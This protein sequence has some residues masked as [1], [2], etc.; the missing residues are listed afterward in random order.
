MNLSEYFHMG[1]YALYVWLSY[2]L[3]LAVIVVH[4]VHPIR[5]ERRLLARI[6][7]RLKREAQ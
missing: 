7:R 1:G 5:R 6:A 4:L 2:G 3:T